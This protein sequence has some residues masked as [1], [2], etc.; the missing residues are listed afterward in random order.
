MRQF[1][2]TRSSN[3]VENNKN[4]VLQTNVATHDFLIFYIGKT[5]SCVAVFFHNFIPHCGW[6]HPKLPAAVQGFVNDHWLQCFRV[7]GYA[8]QLVF[9]ALKMAIFSKFQFHRHNQGVGMSPRIS[10][11]ST[12][13]GLKIPVNHCALCSILPPLTRIRP[14]RI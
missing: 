12:V 6:A 2:G 5:R 10:R 9:H 11:S 4:R 1:C 3:C 8:K 13:S 7:I 14:W